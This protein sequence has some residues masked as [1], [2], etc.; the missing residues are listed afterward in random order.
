VSVAWTAY[1]LAAPCLG[2]IAPAARFF[3]SPR[4][5]ALWSERLGEV[6]GAA[7]PHAWIHAA[8]L[9]ETL[10]V[11]PLLAELRALQPGA[12]FWL[13][14]STLAGRSRLEALPEPVSLAPLDAPQIV[15]RFFA[16][17][18]PRRLVLIETEL[19]PHWLLQARAL[20]VPVAVVSARLSV[21]SARR[22]RQLGT[23]F[24]GLLSGLDAVLCQSHEDAERWI[25]VGAPPAR[26]GVTGNLKS[27]ALPA[28]APHRGAARGELG[29]D[30]DR[31]VLVLG[32]VRPGEIRLLARAWRELP[33]DIRRRWSVVAVPRHPRASA[34]LKREARE[35]GIAP[36]SRAPTPDRSADAASDGARDASPSWRWDDR[37]GVLSRYY[38]VADA[39]FVGGSLL[40]Y[41][42]H[43]PL[44]PAAC[45]AAVLMG[46]FHG[47]QRSGVATLSARHAILVARNGREL[48]QHLGELLGDEPGCRRRGE[49]AR[50]AVEPLRGAAKRAAAMLAAWRV[51]PVE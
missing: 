16:R 26:V 38:A 41:G 15:G 8:S 12:R 17:V 44:E 51:W 21:R 48:G 30:R 45:G 50:L 46:S 29:L 3:A 18:R 6:A 13:T 20:G 14:A 36:A 25:R 24:R 11:G 10:G 32:S 19:W 47:S 28:P 40:P 39:A 23:E 31:P 1:R 2:A 27:D 9:G 7:D 34:E 22:Y 33:E 43:N 5:R 49:A 35:A 37:L 4:E 42:G